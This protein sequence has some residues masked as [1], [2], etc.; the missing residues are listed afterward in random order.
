MPR[1]LAT[2]AL[3]ALLLPAPSAGGPRPAPLVEAVKIGHLKAVRALLQ[4][5][6]DVNAAEPGGST[7]LHWAAHR[8]DAQVV[9]RLPLNGGRAAISNRYGVQ[10]LSLAAESGD[11]RSVELLLKAGADSNTTLPGGETALMTAAR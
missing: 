9:E 4:Q 2:V 10:P 3:T 8:G 6:V 5:R 7:A 11:A 1:W